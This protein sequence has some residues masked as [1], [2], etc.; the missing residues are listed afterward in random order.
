M[1][2]LE[3]W[4]FF[5]SFYSYQVPSLCPVSNCSLPRHPTLRTP[6][7]PPTP[8]CPPIPFRS[9]SVPFPSVIIWLTSICPPRLWAL[10]RLSFIWGVCWGDGSP[11]HQ[12]PITQYK[13]VCCLWVFSSP[14]SHEDQDLMARGCLEIGFLGNKTLTLFFFLWWWSSFPQFFLLW[15]KIH[16]KSIILTIFKCMV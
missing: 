1:R 8:F 2:S 14:V 3:E 13:W 12:V 5:Y 7:P 9:G 11:L 16:I 15:Y 4:L 6:P 10:R